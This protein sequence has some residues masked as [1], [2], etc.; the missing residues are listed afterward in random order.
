MTTWVSAPVTAEYL[1]DLPGCLAIINGDPQ[2]AKDS[3]GALMR[4]RRRPK[5]LTNEFYRNVTGDCAAYVETRGFVAAPRSAEERDFPIAYSMVIH[6]QIEMFERLLRALYQPQNVYCVHVDAKSPWDFLD[7][8]RSIVSCFPNDG[9]GDLRHVVAGAGG[10][11]LHGGP[12]ALPVP[13]RYMLN[14]CGTDFPIKT[15][16]E[17][18]KALLLLRGHNSM[19][20]EPTREH[21]TRRWRYHHEVTA[22][23]IV[24]T[25]EEKR[26]PPIASPMFQGNAYMVATRDFVR[27]VIEDP[28]IQAFVEWEKDTYCPDEHMWATMQRMPSVPGSNPADGKYDESDMTAVARLV[29]WNGLDGERSEGAPYAPCTGV[30]RR[31]VCVYGAGDLHWVLRQKHLL[32]NKFDHEVDDVS[33]RCLEAYLHFK[34]WGT[35]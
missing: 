17:M 6:G 32:A 24:Q 15:N 30:Y 8:V 13:W 31:S 19:E 4:A 3:F 2:A 1:E 18:V 21:K 20:S 22:D 25:E 26:P 23:S 34:A 28:E 35:Q 9:G 10:P 7:A 12:A 29:K 5:G 33:I 16:A 27:H 11:E 14:T